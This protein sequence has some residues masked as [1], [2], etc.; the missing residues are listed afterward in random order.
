MI[1]FL[2]QLFCK[3]YRQQWVRNIYGDEII[4]CGWN[5]SIWKC[6]HCE[7]VFFDPYLMQT[8]GGVAT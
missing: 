1:K 6:S 2:K 7:K 8:S 5:R 4:E 3:H